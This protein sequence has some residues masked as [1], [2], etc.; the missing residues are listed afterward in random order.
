MTE[1]A[2][3]RFTEVQLEQAIITLLGE[4]GYPHF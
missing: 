2:A 1:A 4:Q 3:T